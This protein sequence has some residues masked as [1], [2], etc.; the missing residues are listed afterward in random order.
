M[1]HSRIKQLLEVR[2]YYLAAAIPVFATVGKLP[3]NHY[4]LDLLNHFQSYYMVFS[5]VIFI[6]ALFYFR[7]RWLTVL[8]GSALLISFIPLWLLISNQQVTLGTSKTDK[9]LL[10]VITINT[11]SANTEHQRI[12]DF[13]L[14]EQPDLLS[15]IELSHAQKA[16]LHP[17]LK[18]YYPHY[19][20]LPENTPAGIGIYSR[21]PIESSRFVDLHGY[22]FGVIS[23]TIKLPQQSINFLALHPVPPIPQGGHDIRNELLLRLP[24]FIDHQDNATITSGDFNITLWSPV[25]HQML[26]QLDAQVH[27]LTPATWPNKPLMPKI[28]I[29][30]I[31][32][33]K[34]LQFIS[35]GKGSDI[36]SDH[37]PVIA[38]IGV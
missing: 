14:N 1:N 20:L 2:S 23:S 24:E 19:F 30:H 3:A 34:S 38:V 26:E 35:I 9:Q 29:D 15:I 6:A 31:L 11:N 4:A 10:K 7:K 8:S 5:A 21:Y 17:Q 16:F 33:S 22:H 18:H 37:L 12:L 32:V 25:F 27:L 13:I 28:A 36:G